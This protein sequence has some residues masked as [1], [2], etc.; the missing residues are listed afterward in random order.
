MHLLGIH[1]DQRQTDPRTDLL[2][3]HSEHDVCLLGPTFGLSAAARDTE[4]L[5]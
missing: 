3:R 4:M 5:L 2:Y 1:V